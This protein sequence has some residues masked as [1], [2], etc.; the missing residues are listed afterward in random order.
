MDSPHDMLAESLPLYVHAQ[1]MRNPAAYIFYPSPPPP[2][3]QAISAPYPVSAP[4]AAAILMLTAPTDMTVLVAL[5][6]VAARCMS[7]V[8]PAVCTR[9]SSHYSAAFSAEAPNPSTL[10]THP[11]RTSLSSASPSAGGGSMWSHS[12]NV[13]WNETIVND[14]IDVEK[15]LS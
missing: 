6:T 1:L 9:T 14:H 10:S 3:P 5:T 4:L 15:T 2:P 7:T 8:C 11:S 12:Q 13:A